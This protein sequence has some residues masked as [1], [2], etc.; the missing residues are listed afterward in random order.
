MVK[1]RSMLLM[2]GGRR[3]WL[4]M[5]AAILLTLATA[6][7]GSGSGGGKSKVIVGSKN[8]T[9][10]ILVGEMTA[11]LL[12]DAGYP[13]ERKLN[14]GGTAV[15]HQALTSGDINTYIEYTGTG[16]TAILK[17][18]VQTDPQQVYTTVKGEYEKQ[19]KVTWLN[20][21]GFNN[22][23]ALAMRKDQ[24]TELGVK[25]ISDL[26]GK[27]DSLTFG[28]TQEFLT[29]PDGLPGMTKAYD[30]KFKDPKGMD[31]GITYQA[32]ASKQVD[33]ISAFATDGRIPALNLV[34]LQDDQ[35][36]FPP[37]FAASVVRQDLL[38]KDPKV[39]D[40]LNKLGGKINDPT[41][42]G[43]NLQ[44]DQD[45]KEPRDVARAFLKQQGLLK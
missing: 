4:L 40:V 44:V 35:H 15:V 27:S 14:L 17:L 38:S 24:A 12:E 34:I 7:G 20:P 26:K 36:F 22:T 30:L 41:M 28:A 33:V 13:V 42:A 31:A 43:L 6:C 5:L 39:A 23:Y 2:T 32:L 37:Y 10:N 9:E 25:T 21:L 16:L 8:F 18:P 1:R 19:F 29:R 45:K 3:P 11:L